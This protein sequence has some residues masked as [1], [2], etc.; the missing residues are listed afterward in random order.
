MGPLH[1]GFRVLGG[2]GGGG[3]FFFFFFWMD[4]VPKETGIVEWV[5]MGT[6]VEDWAQGFRPK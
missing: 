4:G 5:W 2:G 6:S 3:R 1:F